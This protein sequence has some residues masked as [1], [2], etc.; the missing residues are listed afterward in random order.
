M[1]SEAR[2]EN[3]S[4][5]TMNKQHIKEIICRAK[6][7]KKKIMEK[8][9]RAQKCSI[10]GPQNLGSRGGPGPRGPPGSAP[11]QF[12]L[13]M[14]NIIHDY[15][16]SFCMY[17]MPWLAF[18]ASHFRSGCHWLCGYHVKATDCTPSIPL[19]RNKK[20]KEKNNKSIVLLHNVFNILTFNEDSCDF[21][22]WIN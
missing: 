13:G 5:W 9:N 20:F 18:R 12:S 15:A 1:P 19:L 21:Y 2:L 7:G 17:N 8:L 16:C 11:V 6:R 14:I 10:L 22:C 3:F 4:I